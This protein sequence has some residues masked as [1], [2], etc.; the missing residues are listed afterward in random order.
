MQDVKMWMTH[1]PMTI[2]S[3]A[4]ALEA[5]DRMQ[6]NDIR[7]LPVLAASGALVGILSL[8]DLRAALPL[9]VT[10]YAPPAERDRSVAR[11]YVVGELMTYAPAVIAPVELLA[12]AARKLVEGHIGCLPVVARSGK[13]VG[14][15]T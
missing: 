13:L 4:S 9:E 8:D 6:E 5:L 1:P 2:E 15:L 7:H 12:S 10:L 3:D 11:E 14:I